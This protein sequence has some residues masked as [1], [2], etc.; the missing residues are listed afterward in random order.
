MAT[1]TVA[2]TYD[3]HAPMTRTQGLESGGLE[4][5]GLESEPPI[6]D[7]DSYIP[8]GGLESES[9]HLEPKFN[10]CAAEA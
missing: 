3:M 4:S 10:A 7:L 8:A 2:R 6:L 9:G 1:E 5:G